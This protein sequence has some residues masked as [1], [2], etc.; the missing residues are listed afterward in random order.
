MF[1]KSYVISTLLKILCDHCFVGDSIVFKTTEKENIQ[2][3]FIYMEKKSTDTHLSY[4][5]WTKKGLNNLFDIFKLFAR[6]KP[7]DFD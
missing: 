4:L 2:R 3:Y 6:F 1:L 5:P 7:L